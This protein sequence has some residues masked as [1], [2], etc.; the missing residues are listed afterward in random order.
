MNM[1][2]QLKTVLALVALMQGCSSTDNI[3]DIDTSNNK[4]MSVNVYYNSL[5]EDDAKALQ[6]KLVDKGY[7]V[8]VEKNKPL[9]SKYSSYIYVSKKDAKSAVMLNSIVRDLLK[10]NLNTNF[11]KDKEKSGIAKI[12]L[13]NT[14]AKN[15]HIK[16]TKKS[17]I[18]Q[19]W[20]HHKEMKGLPEQCATKGIE[21]LKSLG[22]SSVVKNGNYVY[23]NFELNRATIKCVGVDKHTFVY[24]AVAGKN[25]KQVEQLRNKISW[26]L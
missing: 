15:S 24:T 6:N 16:N 13:T 22:F 18:P 25:V 2:L 14:D 12:I 4:I 20:S 7:L 11:F 17:Y 26:K 21:I 9:S 23:G 1:N 19:L 8:R 3:E 5:R 10:H